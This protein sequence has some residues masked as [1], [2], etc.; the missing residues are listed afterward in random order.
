VVLVLIG[1]AILALEHTRKKV[2][3]PPTHSGAVAPALHLKLPE[4][5]APVQARA[6]SATVSPAKKQLLAQT[7]RP[8]APG[9]VAIIIDDMGSNLQEARTLI[10]IKLPVTFSIIP[11]LAQAKGVAEAAHSAGTEV[12]VHMPME[13]QGYPKQRMEQVGL[14]VSMEN[15]EIEQRV[16]GYFTA[17]PFAVGANNH[18]GSRFTEDAEKME[19]V[20]K[21]LK[22]RG[23]F[24]VDSRTSS[25]SVGYQ[26]ARALGL[27]CAARQVFLD[28]VQEEGAIRKQLAQAAAVARKKGSAIA[29][30]HPHPSTLRVL[31]S[32]MPELARDGIIFVPA[33]KLV[34]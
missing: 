19:T 18:M 33:S 21:V 8:A 14:L 32:M 5:K 34:G 29:I 1:L 7:A 20:L 31:K 15:P 28:N 9:S 10:S 30:C 13:P 22:E 25:A 4:R 16:R 24:F 6:S 2:P 26:T 27:K 12:M 23:V 11:S 17:V 3:L